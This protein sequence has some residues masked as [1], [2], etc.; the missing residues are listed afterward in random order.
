MPANL[1]QNPLASED[2]LFSMDT[3]AWDRHAK[4]GI[5]YSAQWA[6]TFTDLYCKRLVPPSPS[7][8]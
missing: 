3:Y 5:A 2:Q 7:V 1:R 8:S 6:V 4:A